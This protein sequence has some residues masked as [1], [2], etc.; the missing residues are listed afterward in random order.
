LKFYG[1]HV[2]SSDLIDRGYAM[3][4]SSP[5]VLD[6]LK[7]AP[8]WDKDA[9]ITNPP[10]KLAEPFLHMAVRHKPKKIAFLLRLSFLEGSRRYVSLFRD[11]PPSRVLVLSARPTLWHGADPEIRTSGGAISYAWFVWDREDYGKR[12]PPRL[13]WLG[14]PSNLQLAIQANRNARGRLSALLANASN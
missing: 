10:Y 6:F 7:V 3:P 11:T 5:V 4:A 8:F 12:L 1:Y 9:I 13:Y 2:Y 14:K